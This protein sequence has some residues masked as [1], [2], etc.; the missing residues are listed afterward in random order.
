MEDLITDITNQIIMWTF[1]GI[2]ITIVFTVMMIVFIR[3]LVS[4]NRQLL[5]TG[6]LAQ[7]TILETSQ[8]SLM[9]NNNPQVKLLLEV[10]P[11]GRPSYQVETK[12]IV[13]LVK[14]PQVQPGAVI[15]I[16]FDPMNPTKVA[17][18]L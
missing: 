7:A 4:P 10:Q 17:L 14:I 3:K 15:P 5:S 1:I 13:P 2:G 8:T 16:R 9:V 12:C 6:E 11:S 18:E